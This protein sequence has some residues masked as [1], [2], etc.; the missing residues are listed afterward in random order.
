MAGT[1]TSGGFAVLSP[2]SMNERSNMM[3]RLCVWSA[4]LAAGAVFWAGCGKKA[5]QGGPA[6]RPP[7]QVVAVAA[8]QEPIAEKLSQIGNVVANEMVAI[9]SEIDGT[10]EEILFKEGEH[11][12]KGKLLIRLDETKLAASVAEAEA[13]FALSKANF[14]RSKQ[15][16]KDHLI[17]QQ[18][19][20]QTAASYQA[21]E[22]SL[23]LQ[24]RQ[25][26]DARIFAPFEGVMGQRNVSPG[27]VIAK[28]TTLSWVVDID[29]VKLEISVPERFLRELRVGQTIDLTVTAYPGKM[30]KGEV[31]FIAPQV[32]P[33]TRTAFIK[34]RIPN[35]AGDLKPGMF[36]SLDLTLQLRDKAI[37]VPEVAL[38]QILEEDEATLY[39]VD[40]AHTAQMKRVRL[41]LRM[42]G[43]VEVVKGVKAGEMVIVEG[44]QKVAPGAKV[45]LAPPAASEPYLKEATKTALTPNG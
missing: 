11:V 18:D 31:F 36:A 12:E 21:T 44:T 17:S 43:W 2:Y 8:R 34:A 45:S 28:N 26:K 10:V 40:D 24:K 16:F 27:Q 38:S 33:D 41:G 9:K 20:D 35:P 37:L 14:E 7:V 39:V 13:S 6:G 5:A 22:A 1:R 19:Y 4:T 32:D 29:P 30:F 3:T 25:L 42:P 23:A 15:L